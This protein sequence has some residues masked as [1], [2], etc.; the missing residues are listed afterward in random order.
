MWRASATASAGS[1]PDLLS[2]PEV[3]TWCRPSHVQAHASVRPC[4]AGQGPTS[5][6]QRPTTSAP[7]STGRLEATDALLLLSLAKTSTRG[8]TRR[9]RRE[10]HLHHDVE[11]LHPPRR[12][13]R[14]IQRILIDKGGGR[15][16]KKRRR[17]GARQAGGTPRCQLMPRDTARCL[18]GHRQ[19]PRGHLAG[20]GKMAQDA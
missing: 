16:G 1:H 19:M 17:A 10:T 5:N 8:E 2:S 6:A 7:S 13:A 20:L 18:L 3:S 4:M 15:R 9:K 11:P 14:L 12:L